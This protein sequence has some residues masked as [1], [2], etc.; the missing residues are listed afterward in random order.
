MRRPWRFG[1]GGFGRLSHIVHVVADGD[2]E[3]EE[4]VFLLH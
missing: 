4:P 1:E 2:E 3:V